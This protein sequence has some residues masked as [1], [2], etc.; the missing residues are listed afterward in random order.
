MTDEPKTSPEVLAAW[1][2]LMLIHRE[3][4]ELQHMGVDRPFS[5]SFLFD[6]RSYLQDFWREGYNL[7]AKHHGC[8]EV[9]K[10]FHAFC[11]DHLVPLHIKTSALDARSDYSGKKIPVAEQEKLLDDYNKFYEIRD[12]TLKKKLEEILSDND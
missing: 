10:V 12:N 1:K 2:L 5:G 6:R 11:L 3:L 4:G 8:D 7:L 9:F